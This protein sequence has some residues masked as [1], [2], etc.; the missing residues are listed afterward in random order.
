MTYEYGLKFNNFTEITLTT[1]KPDKGKNNKKI[2]KINKKPKAKDCTWC[3]K[4]NS[5]KLLGHTWNN[6]FR[7]KKH[8]KEKKKESKDNKKQEANIAMETQNIRTKSF[9]FNMACTSH[10]TP[11]SERLQ[12]FRNCSEHIES[13]SKQQMEIKGNGDLV[14]E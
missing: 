6:C 13:S 5:S 10:M 9:Y 7:L 12:N 8:N 1:V 14:L 11:F 3:A 2:K 4:H